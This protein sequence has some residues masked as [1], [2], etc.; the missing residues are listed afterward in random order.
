VLREPHLDETL[1]AF[2]DGL[3]QSR[4]GHRTTGTFKISS[5]DLCRPRLIAL[6]LDT[7]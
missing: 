4:E 5:G 1:D 2:R 7:P 3:G 6:Q